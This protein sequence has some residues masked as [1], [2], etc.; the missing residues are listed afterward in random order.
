MSSTVH[1]SSAVSASEGPK[2]WSVLYGLKV[3]RT[4]W[5][6]IM[7][8]DRAHF[9]EESVYEHLRDVGLIGPAHEMPRWMKTHLRT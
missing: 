7:K 8:T 2:R 6:F 5:R 4:V 1:T 3:Y 9:S